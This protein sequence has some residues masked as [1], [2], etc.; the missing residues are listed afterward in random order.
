MKKCKHASDERGHCWVV[1]CDN[2]RLEHWPFKPGAKRPP[3]HTQHDVSAIHKV[4][5]ASEEES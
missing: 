1:G 3:T 5:K 4:H 2:N